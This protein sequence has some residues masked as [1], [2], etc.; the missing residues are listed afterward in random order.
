VGSYQKQ[1]KQ[2]VKFGGNINFDTTK[3]LRLGASGKYSSDSFD[4][5]KEVSHP[6]GRDRVKS[7]VHKAKGKACSRSQSENEPLGM[8]GTFKSLHNST[9][10]LR[11]HNCGS[12]EIN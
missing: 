8:R 12:N 3:R 5:E 6:I 1:P 7:V 11:R 4:T 2:S 9:R 10:Y